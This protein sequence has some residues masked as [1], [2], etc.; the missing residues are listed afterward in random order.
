[1]W[2]WFYYLK[3]VDRYKFNVYLRDLLKKDIVV[4]IRFYFLKVMI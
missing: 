4:V 2:I 3:V 1:M